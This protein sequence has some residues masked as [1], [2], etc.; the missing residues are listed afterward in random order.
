[1]AQPNYKSP[2][3]PLRI[4]YIIGKLVAGGVESVVYN[5]YRHMDHDKIQF[6]IIYD[7]DSSQKPPK[8]L[9]DM[10]A[11]FIE[12][13]PYQK[14]GAYIKF[15]ED[16][17]RS[18]Q[19]KIAHSH[20]NT[21]SV[22]SLY[23]A[24]RAGIPVRIAHSHSTAARGKDIKRDLLKYALRPFTKVYANKFFACSEHAGR[25]MYG[26]RTYDKGQVTIIKNAIDI[27]KFK[28]SS[29]KREQIRNNYGI[30]DKFVI[31]HV[32]RYTPQKNHLFIIEVF[33]GV[34]AKRDDAVL[35]LIG[36]RDY[37]ENSIYDRVHDRVNRYG[38]TDKV[39]FVEPQAD[40]SGFYSAM[41]V[42][43]L[44]S[45]YEGLAVVRVEALSAGCPCLVS[46]GNTRELD[47]FDEGFLGIEERNVQ[48]WVDKTL[49]KRER[50][51]D[52][53]QKMNEAGFD[54]RQRAEELKQHYLDLYVNEAARWLT[55][56]KSTVEGMHNC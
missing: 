51:S 2:H 30:S 9:V 1:V 53:T 29:E 41:D 37:G 50:I 4:A 32:G 47:L 55:C 22:F 36:S 31:G 14:L 28:F 26:N 3:E 35:I 42:F 52:A 46:A 27:D 24:K 34:C 45:L 20:M 38:L 15:L 44:P 48:Q 6:E 13:P 43:I 21:L 17:F 40:V 33:R 54:V 8:D 39:I 18:Q 19:Y 49:S 5:Y 25:W 10:G 11:R 16:L 7:A 23:A 56:K 12:C